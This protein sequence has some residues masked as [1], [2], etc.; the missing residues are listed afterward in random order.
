VIQDADSAQVVGLKY[1]EL[2]VGTG[3]EAVLRSTTLR[4]SV[5]LVRWAFPHHQSWVS[6]VISGDVVATK[7]PLNWSPSSAQVGAIGPVEC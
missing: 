1:R 6:W 7:E 4:D 2:A 3:P 5:R